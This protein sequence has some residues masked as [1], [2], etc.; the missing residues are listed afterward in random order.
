MKKP[1]VYTI[2]HPLGRCQEFAAP[3]LASFSDADVEEYRNEYACFKIQQR[4]AEMTAQQMY[5]ELM[6][7]TELLFDDPNSSK[8]SKQHKYMIRMQK[9]REDFVALHAS[10]Y[11]TPKEVERRIRN[12]R[13]TLAN[14][15]DTI[16]APMTEEAR[17]ANEAAMTVLE[18]EGF[19]SGRNYMPS[20][21]AAFLRAYNQTAES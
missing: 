6:H 17:A 21:A 15:A 2:K 1:Q 11:L 18:Q 16:T 8:Y 5:Y 7:L 14:R 4:K 10:K 19:E 12:A 3:L 13:E 9:N 20:T